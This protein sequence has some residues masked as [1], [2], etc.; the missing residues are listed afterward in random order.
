MRRLGILAALLFAV[1]ALT[2]PLAQA[3][4]TTGYA[5]WDPLVGVS[6]DYTS[7]MRLPALGFPEATLTSDSRAGSVGVQSGA[8]AFF[9]ASTPIGVKYGSSQNRPYLS[10]RPKADGPTTPST[11]TFTFA[12]PT[13]PTGW[14]FVLGDIDADQVSVS[15]KDADGNP[16]TASGLGFAGGFNFCDYGSPRPSGCSGSVSDVPSWDPT[17]RTLVGNDTATDTTGAVGWFEPTTPLSSLTL[18]FTRRSGFPLYQVWFASVARTI[19]GTATDVSTA[20]ATCPVDGST[21]ELVGPYG[22]ILDTTTPALD[23][24]YSFGQYATQPGYTVRIEVPDTCSVV[25]PPSQVISTAGDDATAE[26]Q[27]RQIVPNPVSG[28]VTADG[29]PFAGIEVTLHIPG[30]G[31]KVTSTDAHGGYLFDDNAAANGYYVTIDVPEGYTGLDQRPPFNMNDQPIT[32][33]DFALVAAPDVSGNVTGGGNGLGGVKVTLEPSGGGPSISTVTDGDGNYSFERVPPGTY[34]IAIDPPSGYS[35]APARTG[36]VVADDDVVNQ[37]FEL[38][39][40]GAIGGTIHLDTAN[41]PVRA[42]VAIEIVGPGGT[43]TLTSDDEGNFFLDG[44]LP[45]DYEIHVVLPK[46]FEGVGPINRSVTITAEGEIRGAQDFV[47]RQ[48]AT[49]PT[50][51]PTPTNET[52]TN[53]PTNSPPLSGT[54]DQIPDT[55]NPASLWMVLLGFGL[56]GIGGGAMYA[57]MRR[58]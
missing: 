6:N 38:D 37:D 26:F 32:G 3:V 49:A 42:G 25:G 30:G 18:T 54:G 28:V 9:N 11:T 19:S 36:V 8:S 7:A 56:L 27:V 34:D 12:R 58:R 24:S 55:G 15:A 22:D 35:P 10:L 40:N 45:G 20:P 39:R 43:R 5:D 46:G 31:T 2:A 33:E 48:R 17:T 1:A 4:R 52:P 29:F 14:M 51:S 41:G 13:P 23:G 16:V 53:S 47:I 50:S 44:L 21:V 57:A